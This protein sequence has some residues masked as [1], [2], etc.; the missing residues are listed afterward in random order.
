MHPAPSIILFTVLS[1]MG[2]GLLFFLGLGFGSTGSIALVF[3]VLAFLLSTGGLLA[4]TF[5][6]GHPERALKAFSQWR[7]SWLSREGCCAVF[8]L[9]VM[10]ILAAGRVFSAAHWSWIGWLGSTFCV[11]TVLTT[12]M[13]YA[14]LRTVPRWNS[15]LTPSLF[16]A[17]AASGGALLVG[18]LDWARLLLA[19]TAGIQLAWWL[20]GDRALH[21]SGTSLKTA[22]GLGAIGNPRSLE[23]PHTEANYLTREMAFVIARH[24][25][26]LLRLVAAILAFALPLILLSLP[27]SHLIAAFAVL[28]HTLGALVSR[29]LFFAEAEHVVSFYYG[30]R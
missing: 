9:V 3:F 11:A 6:L 21:H 7:T 14:Q 22:T 25:A 24:H 8:A 2:F 17:Y 16:L 5:H 30:V 27:H 28:L 29:W 18:E 4:S 19:I 10:T 12:S 20:R 23:S 1:G 13:I 26:K 15:A